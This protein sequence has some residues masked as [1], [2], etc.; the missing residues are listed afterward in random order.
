MYFTSVQCMSFDSHTEQ[1]PTNEIN[2]E[3]SGYTRHY[4]RIPAK[5]E[6][7]RPVLS[8]FQTLYHPWGGESE[9]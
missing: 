3:N 7:K 4:D 2:V 8:N 9:H 1:A 5:S 6:G